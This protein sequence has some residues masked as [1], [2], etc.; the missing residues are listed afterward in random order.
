ML[1]NLLL[2]R[3]GLFQLLMLLGL[4]VAQ[5]RGLISYLFTGDSMP[6]VS[7]ICA[8]F[9]VTWVMTW[10]HALRIARRLN[11]LKRGSDAT[12]AS[13]AERDKAFSKIEWMHHVSDWLVG[14]GLIGTV[15]GFAVAL[16]GVDMD[17][18][19]SVNGAQEMVGQLIAGTRLAIT[20]TIAGAI[21]GMWNQVNQRMLKTAHECYWH[22]RLRGVA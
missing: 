8:V 2:Y 12:Q 15:I 4:V 14:L 7:L 20:T 17:A 13:P 5:T 22:D 18:I 21:L 3:L 9:A 1:T 10:F 19:R 16:S 6:L 11:G